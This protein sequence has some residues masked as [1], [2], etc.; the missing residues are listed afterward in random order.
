MS[1]I[2]Q[3]MKSECEYVIRKKHN[4]NNKYKYIM[5][6][7]LHAYCKSVMLAGG[8]SFKTAAL[9]ILRTIIFLIPSREGP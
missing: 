9:Y 3:R 7:Y 6:I 2:R 5:I 1:I 4:K 8:C